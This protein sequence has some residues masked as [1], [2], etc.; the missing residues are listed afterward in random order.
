MGRGRRDDIAPLKD[1]ILDYIPEVHGW[2]HL[3]KRNSEKGSHG[4]LHGST[5]RLL[6]ATHELERFDA[7]PSAYVLRSQARQAL[8]ASI[9]VYGWR[10]RGE[11]QDSQ[12]KLHELALPRWRI[13][14]RRYHGRPAARGNPAHC[15]CLMPCHAGFDLVMPSTCV[16]RSCG[17]YLPGPRL[18]LPV[19]VRSAVLDVPAR[20]GVRTSLPSSPSSSCMPSSS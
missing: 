6:C 15:E 8:I 4:W 17:I 14:P 2:E 13:Q 20:A 1:D 19:Q 12:L 16:H 10:D 7:D 3:T 11:H 18:R 9:Q 5:A